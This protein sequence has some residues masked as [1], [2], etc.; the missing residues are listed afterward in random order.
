VLGNHDRRALK[1]V[2]RLGLE[3]GPSLRVGPHVVLHGDDAESVRH[4]RCEAHERGGRVFV[5]HI[6][7]A[8]SL[9][10]GTGGAA[11]VP[12]FVTAR[13]FVCVPALSPYSRGLDVRGR[14]VREQLAALIG[15]DERGAAV[16][17]D[18]RVMPV[19]NVWGAPAE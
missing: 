2:E 7:P 13:S 4:A 12:A 1:A 14:V 8:L 10:D 5:G 3:H 17:V 11:F 15:D 6:H 16:V 19:G 9:D 18:G